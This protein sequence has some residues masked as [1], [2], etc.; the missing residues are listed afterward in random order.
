MNATSDTTAVWGMAIKRMSRTFR[1]LVWLVPLVGLLGLGFSSTGAAA[2]DSP[3]PRPAE[4]K[5]GR[6]FLMPPAERQR[7]CDLVAREGWAREELERL[8]QQ[9]AGGDGFLSAF[10]YAVERDPRHLPVVIK[11]LLAECGPDA[12]WVK[13][14]NAALADPNYFTGGQP[15][16]PDVYYNVDT[17]P[18]IAF[19]WVHD[20]LAPGDRRTI[21]DGLLTR[22]RY[23]MRAMDRW[24]QTP[25]LVFKPT[26]VV[27]VTGLV[28][29]DP[30]CLEWG[31]RRTKP[32]GP[33]IGGYFAVLDH[34]L[35]D[36]GAWHESPIYPIAHLDLILSA[37]MSRYLGLADGQDWFH[38]PLPGGGSP[39]GLMDYYLDTAYPIEQAGDERQ[40]RIANYGDGSTNGGG[41]LFLIHTGPGDQSRNILVHEPLAAA[42]AVSGDPRY[43]AFLAML[44]DYQPSLLGNRPLPAEK[45]ALPP[46]PSKVWPRYGLAM[47]RSDESPAYWTSGE[48]LAVFQIMS[49]GYGHDH[50]DKF[51]L[52]LHGAGRLFYPDYNAIQYENMAIGW[53][54]NSVS[55][56]TLMVDEQD[57]RDAVPT[58]LRHDFNPDVKF[59]AT[60]AGGVF[61]RD[62][63]SVV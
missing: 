51:S 12:Y 48:A 59:L 33:H 24:T 62:R 60:A 18:M 63:K 8:T 7:I 32:W 34:M 40:I 54:R 17:K 30:E 53:T 22:A 23:R 11:W 27:A 57:T 10:L 2:D 1:V 45:T 42:Y 16:I 15:G 37:Q 28:T 56:N 13:K 6:P 20:G 44:P 39:G 55:H 3:L 41:D 25:N 21:Q 46:A 9:A 26:Y 19:D 49:Q 58:G 50:R 52:T 38:R 35:Y 14:Y 4:P 29:R 43:A 47:L 36:G 31:F 5:H 61:E